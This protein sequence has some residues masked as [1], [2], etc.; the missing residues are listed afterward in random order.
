MTRHYFFIYY[1]VVDLQYVLISTVQQTDSVI[2]MCVCV[3][4][5]TLYFVFKYSLPYGLSLEGAQFEGGGRGS[6]CHSPWGIYF[7]EVIS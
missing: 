3:C 2:H 4:V 6:G 5:Y 7:S 1:S